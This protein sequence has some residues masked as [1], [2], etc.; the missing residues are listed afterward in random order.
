MSEAEILAGFERTKPALWAW[1]GWPNEV[2]RLGSKDLSDIGGIEE[3][4]ETVDTCL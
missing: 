1:F 3:Y 4:W 2:S